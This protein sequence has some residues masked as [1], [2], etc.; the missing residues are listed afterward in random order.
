MKS[1]SNEW[2]KQGNYI[3]KTNSPQ[4]EIQK[5]VKIEIKKKEDE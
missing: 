4:F 2:F 5:R 1:K 3:S